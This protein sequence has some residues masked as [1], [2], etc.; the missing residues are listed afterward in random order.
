[1]FA[2]FSNRPRHV[3]VWCYFLLKGSRE[4]SIRKKIGKGKT[5]EW[6]TDWV[7]WLAWSSRAINYQLGL[8][9]WNSLLL[10][11][12]LIY[13]ALMHWPNVPCNS[14]LAPFPH[15]VI[16]FYFLV[17]MLLAAIV[18]CIFPANVWYFL[19]I[20]SSFSFLT[21]TGSYFLSIFCYS[22]WLALA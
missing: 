20:F 5:T 16:F 6:V 13:R 1:M 14:L 22:Y 2:F 21:I 18:Q 12:L 10:L 4:I 11:H 17:L 7:K 9:Y 15:T 19:F 3:F 8:F